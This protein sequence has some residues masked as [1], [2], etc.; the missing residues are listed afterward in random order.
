MTAKEPRVS[1]PRQIS[2]LKA[3]AASLLTGVQWLNETQVDPLKQ[4]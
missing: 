4:R 3:E 2:S 1:P